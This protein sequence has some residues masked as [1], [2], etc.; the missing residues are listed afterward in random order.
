MRLLSLVIAITLTTLPVSAA[1]LGC[2]ANPK[3]LERCRFERGDVFM[4]ADIGPVLGLEH[5]QG[6]L[7]IRSA[8]G[9]SKDMP[10]VIANLLSKDLHN[11]V[12]ATYE[13]CPIPSQPDQFPAGT[14]RYV[15][16]NSASH[17]SVTTWMKRNMRETH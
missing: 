13:V 9:S 3:L 6:R 7:I 17:I 16:I 12:E 4:S 2:K 10:S 15:C 5:V 8:P 11:E 1:D 14:Y